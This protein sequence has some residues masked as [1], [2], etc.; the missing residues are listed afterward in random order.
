MGRFCSLLKVLGI[1]V[2]SITIFGALAFS[3]SSG[4]QEPTPTNSPSQVRV[5]APPE[6][7]NP[8][9]LEQ[10]ADQMRAQKAYLDSI[11]YYRAAMKTSDNAILHNKVGMCLLQLRRD[12]EAKKE[13]QHA[14]KENK[15]Y[16]EAYNNLGALYYN[17]RKYGAA[18]REYKKAIKL[19]DDSASFHSNLGGAYFSQKDFDRAA[20]EYQRA[21]EIDPDIFQRQSSASAISIRLVG[22]NDLG[23]FHY[24][25]AQMYGQHG[26]LDHC[27]FYLSKA[28]EEGYPIKGALRDNEFAGLRKKPEFVA[29]VRSLKPPPSG[30]N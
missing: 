19:N 28:N 9:E 14:I 17:L 3:Q 20:K 29:F 6:N 12:S 4:D 27:R 16:A 10:Q 11:D 24:V 1:T 30:N 23:H 25:M 18:I 13:F 21:I 15:E 7:A 5:P 22:S 2:F 26:D 8:V